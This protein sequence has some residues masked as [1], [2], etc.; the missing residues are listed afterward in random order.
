MGD[1]VLLIHNHY[2]PGGGAETHFQS[3]VNALH[4]RGYITYTFSLSANMDG[5]IPGHNF[6]Y[7]KNMRPYYWKFWRYAFHPGIYLALRRVVQRIKPDWIH[8]HVIEQPLSILPALY[9]QVVIH[10]VHTASP[11]C[12]TTFLTHK[13]DLQPCEGG[14]GIKCLRHHCI[15]PIVFLPNC[16]LTFI[17][18]YLL[19]RYVR[20]FIT[21]SKFLESHL[22]DQGFNNI[23][24]VPLFVTE[25]NID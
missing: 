21:P 10:S 14:V 19:K 1:K 6:V 7:W 20:I 4:G 25:P 13:D 17:G 3:L 24:A 18:N 9:D 2:G 23:R 11:V 8:L 5:L 15:R 16:Y 12:L 22:C